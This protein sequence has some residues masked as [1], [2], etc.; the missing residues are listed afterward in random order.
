MRHRQR[1]VI[2]EIIQWV[3]TSFSL[4]F[5][6]TKQYVCAR[7][8]VVTFKLQIDEPIWRRRR[9]RLKH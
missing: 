3:A 4:F 2:H 5:H 8:C 6:R 7:V 1:N 9:R